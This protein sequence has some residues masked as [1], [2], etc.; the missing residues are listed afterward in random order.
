MYSHLLNH[1]RPLGALVGSVRLV[2]CVKNYRSP[3]GDQ[4]SVALR[5]RV[6]PIE[7]CL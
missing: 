2:D 1:D 6:V 5:C 4:W 7:R 3:V